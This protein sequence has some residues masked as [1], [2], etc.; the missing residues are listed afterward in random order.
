MRAGTTLKTLRANRRLTI[1]AVEHASERIAKAKSDRRFHI[2]N[3]WLVQLEKGVSEP[4]LH[5]LFSLS[6]IYETSFVELIQLYDLDVHNASE[7]STFAMPQ[8]TQLLRYEPTI[9]MGGPEN[10]NRQ[11]TSLLSCGLS[12]RRKL[13]VKPNEF[14]QGYIGLNDFTMYPLIRPGSLV[15]IDLLQ[16]KLMNVAW[17]NEFERPIYFIELRDAFACAWCELHDNDLMLIPHHLSRV[18]IRKFEYGKEAEIVGRVVGFD[19][20][21]IDFHVSFQEQ[22]I[23]VA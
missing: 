12:R 16:H 13:A 22:S 8:N 2:S 4:G 9:L 21:C 5:K 20:S 15:R 19:T 6:V 10:L 1:R 11:E 17:R 18:G 3:G 23:D 7:Y 14:C